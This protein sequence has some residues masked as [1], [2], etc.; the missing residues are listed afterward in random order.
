MRQNKDI[1]HATLLENLWTG[2]ILKFNF[3]LGTF[4]VGVHTKEC[5]AW[6]SL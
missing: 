3:E 6:K 2:N 4:M 1:Q 5:F